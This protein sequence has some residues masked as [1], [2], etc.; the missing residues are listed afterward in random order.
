MLD[1]FKKDAFNAVSLTESIDKLPYQPGALGKLG[2]F[3]EKGISTTTAV[4]EWREG[5]ISLL[6]TAARGTMPTVNSSRARKTK[7]FTVPHIPANDTVMAEEVQNVRSFGSE[8]QLEAVSEIVT[9]KLETLKQYHEVTHEYHRI[10]A[11]QG[12]V[13]DGDGST[14]LLNLFTEFGIA[15]TNVNFDFTAG[16]MDVK[17]KVLEVVRALQL[18]LGA[19][20]YTSILAVCGDQFFDRLISHDTVKGAFERWQQGTSKVPFTIEDPNL[21][22]MGFEF[23]GVTWMN[24]RGKIGSVDFIPTATCRFVPIGTKN[25][26]KQYN[27]P[28]NFMEAVNT[29]GKRIYAKQRQMDFDI[30]VEL[31]TQSNPLIICERPAVLI[32]GTDT[33]P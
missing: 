32:K 12:V 8:D 15:E 10:G 21:Q 4:I 18:A 19:E 14:T 27:A 20:T 24:Y 31:H 16:V 29:V 28:A 22:R 30:G 2:L 3:K 5:K 26:F 23:A 7:S 11:I 1:V 13:K 17:L 6:M 33:T 25:I 9:D